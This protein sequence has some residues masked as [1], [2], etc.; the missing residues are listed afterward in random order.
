MVTGTNADLVEWLRA[1]FGG[2]V[3][4]KKRTRATWRPEFIWRLSHAKALD[5]I[6]RLE[7]YLVVKWPQAN[8][9][10]ALDCIKSL[11]REDPDGIV[12]CGYRRGW[13]YGAGVVAG[14]KFITEAMRRFNA[15][16]VT[17]DPWL[18]VDAATASV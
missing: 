14:F 17:E 8:L 16:G 1:R 7:P 15:R 4:W 9:A 6:E 11:A 5:L 3:H 10:L 13:T 2:D 12:T 18:F